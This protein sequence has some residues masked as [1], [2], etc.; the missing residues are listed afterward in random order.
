MIWENSL[1]LRLTGD[2][3]GS[4]LRLMNWNRNLYPS[5]AERTKTNISMLDF[6]IFVIQ[7]EIVE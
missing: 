6:Y 7:S 5:N 4:S 3:D 2:T 1:R